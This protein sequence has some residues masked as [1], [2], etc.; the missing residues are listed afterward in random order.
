MEFFHKIKFLTENT[1][2]YDVTFDVIL[3]TVQWSESETTTIWVTLNILRYNVK[4]VLNEGDKKLCL[5]RLKGRIS[6]KKFPRVI[7]PS[8][9]SR[10]VR[11]P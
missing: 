8:P 9:K 5:E 11:W 1:I 10:F 6:S 4:E 7:E 2:N 3:S